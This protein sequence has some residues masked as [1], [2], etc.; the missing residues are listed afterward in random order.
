MLHAVMGDRAT[1]QCMCWNLQLLKQKAFGP[2][3]SNLQNISRPSASSW[4]EQPCMDFQPVAGLQLLPLQPEAKPHLL[5]LQMATFQCP[6]SKD[7][8]YKHLTCRESN[9][10]IGERCTSSQAKEGRSSYRRRKS[11]K[12]GSEREACRR[13]GAEVNG[14]SDEH[15]VSDVALGQ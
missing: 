15:A 8:F 1:V 11:Y 14:V 9:K 3:A 5:G 2:S 13:Q 6:K 10:L 4:S 12:G 7:K